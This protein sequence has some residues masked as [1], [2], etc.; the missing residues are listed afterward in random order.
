M[1]LAMHE[2]YRLHL[3]DSDTE[4]SLIELNAI[5]DTEIFFSDEHD[6]YLIF[7]RNAFL[8]FDI[9]KFL[10]KHKS[11]TSLQSKLGERESVS[12]RKNESGH[13]FK[14]IAETEGCDPKNSKGQKI[15]LEFNEAEIISRAE[16]KG[17]VAEISGMD[18]IFKVN[19]INDEYFKIHY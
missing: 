8:N 12:I 2:G 11:P 1:E 16:L 4:E 9:L 19:P 18:L 14:I 10:G 13:K 3:F 17:R 15:S 7:V 6:T 5:Q